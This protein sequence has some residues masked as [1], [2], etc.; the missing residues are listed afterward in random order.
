MAS[1]HVTV[2][3]GNSSTIGPTNDI[4]SALCAHWYTPLPLLLLHSMTVLNKVC[5]V[6]YTTS[7]LSGRRP[8]HILGGATSG[9]AAAPCSQPSACSMST[10]S[11][12]PAWPSPAAF[13]TLSQ[14][15]R[16]KVY[17]DYGDEG[18]MTWEPHDEPP[19]VR[20]VVVFC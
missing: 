17:C 8:S 10:S 9:T 5:F 3:P 14:S 2:P 13:N 18:K 4:I 12:L 20:P 1:T 19:K 6:L 16:T 11:S 15:S 7:R